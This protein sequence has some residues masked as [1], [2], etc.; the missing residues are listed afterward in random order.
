MSWIKEIPFDEAEGE[1]KR[2]Y[3]RVSGPENNVDNIM[4]VHSLRPHSMEGHMRLYKNVL[5]HA[6]NTLPKSYLETVGTYVSFLNQCSYCVEHHFSGLKRLLNDK[7]KSAIIYESIQSGNIERAFEPKDLAGLKY[8]KELTLNASAMQ[9]ESIR[10]LR[11]LG[12]SDGEILELNQVVAYFNYANRT[13]L[14]LGVST[15]GDVLGLSPNENSDPS[16]WS[17][18]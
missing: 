5:H 13:V 10:E 15:K 2:L 14:G 17:H 9:E 7:A 6:N 8:A 12:Y 1:L 3:K 16:N 4:G 11:R 18:S